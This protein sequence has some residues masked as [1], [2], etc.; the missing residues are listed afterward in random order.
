MG[1]LDTGI[2]GERE[3]VTEGLRVKAYKIMD[4]QVKRYVNHQAL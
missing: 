3:N 2:V 4:Y 1:F